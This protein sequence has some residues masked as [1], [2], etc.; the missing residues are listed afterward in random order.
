MISIEISGP[1][2]PQR[3]TYTPNQIR[4]MA[5]HV[6]NKCI[7]GAGIGGFVT[8][9]ISNVLAYLMSRFY[10]PYLIYR[11]H[12][13]LLCITRY[14]LTGAVEAPSSAFLTVSVTAAGP[15][16]PSPGNFDPT[17]PT[18]FAG[19]LAG[20][21]TVRL[22]GSPSS[23]RYLSLVPIFQQRAS[24]M[25]RGGTTPWWSNV[26]PGSQQMSY[27]C[28]PNLGSPSTLDCS[29]LRYSLDNK[30]DNIQLGQGEVKFISSGK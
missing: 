19:Y 1:T 10:H 27:S 8:K 2:L 26:P 16:A 6:I 4:G 29:R 3:M 20:A 17:I 18:V 22:G 15:T 11:M 21:G 9:D 12:P 30:A 25:R 23:L 5:G 28:D 24:T 7:V 13:T 14:C